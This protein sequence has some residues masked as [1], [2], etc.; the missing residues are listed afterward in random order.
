MEHGLAKML[1]AFDLNMAQITERTGINFE[2][3]RDGLDYCKA[4]LLSTIEGDEQFALRC[5]Y[6]GPRPN[7]TQLIGPE[8]SANHEKDMQRFID[9][10]G[11]CQRR[12][13][14]TGKPPV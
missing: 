11:L 13:D 6:R 14:I 10:L 12:N 8:R 9:A 3:T 7:V 4:A 1:A 5:Y 2:I